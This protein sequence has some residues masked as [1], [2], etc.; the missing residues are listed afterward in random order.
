MNT[1]DI[2]RSRKEALAETK[3]KKIDKK[4]MR[5]VEKRIKEQDRKLKVQLLLGFRH[6]T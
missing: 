4:E 1:F 3:A 2:Y 5:R 6:E